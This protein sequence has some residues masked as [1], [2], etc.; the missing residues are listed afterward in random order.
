M[1]SLI[2]LEGCFK[3]LPPAL[4]LATFFCIPLDLSNTGLSGIS[5]GANVTIQIIY[6]GRDVAYTR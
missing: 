1:T 4:G 5:D 3:T 2:R 6:D